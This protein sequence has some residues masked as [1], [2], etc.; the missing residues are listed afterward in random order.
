MNMN[1]KNGDRVSLPKLTLD[2][3][4]AMD[5][6]TSCEDN[7]KRYALQLDFLNR[8]IPA[9]ILAEELGGSEVTDV[10]LVALAVLYVKVVNAYTAPVMEAQTKQLRDQLTTLKPIINATVDMSKVMD[11]GKARRGFSGQIV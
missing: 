1:M 6:V 9:D 4:D 2:L 3:S 8:V 7:R 11:A 5:A 10:D